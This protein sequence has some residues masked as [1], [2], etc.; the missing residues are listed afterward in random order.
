MIGLTNGAGENQ[1]LG[2]FWATSYVQV[3]ILVW[4]GNGEVTATVYDVSTHSTI[5]QGTVDNEGYVIFQVPKNDLYA[6]F[7]FNSYQLF[8]QNYK[9]VMV[10]VY[11]YYTNII[12]QIL[13]SL[14]LGL[15]LTFVAYYIY[16]VKTSP[17]IVQTT[18]DEKLTPPPTYVDE[19]VQIKYCGHCGTP[20]PID[21]NYCEKCGKKIS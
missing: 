18:L 13:G 3:G 9:D 12:M 10:K 14:M 2:Y 1:V 6:V 4:G 20:N 17:K 21:N 8:S 16:K 11:Y 15:G 19:K 7:L 5:Q